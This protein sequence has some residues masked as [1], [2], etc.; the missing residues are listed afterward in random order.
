[1]YVFKY[2]LAL[3]TGTCYFSFF[4][5]LQ[6]DLFYFVRCV[7][8]VNDCDCKDYHFARWCAFCSEEMMFS[9]EECDGG[10]T[11]SCVCSGDDYKQDAAQPVS[12]TVIITMTCG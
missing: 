7:D 6:K 10:E 3:V 11:A 1:M 8:Q 5:F 4:F 2:Q 9:M 12:D